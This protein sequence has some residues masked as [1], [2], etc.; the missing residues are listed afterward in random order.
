MVYDPR[1]E[2][3]EKWAVLE[4]DMGELA[5]AAPSLKSERVAM[6][7]WDVMFMKNP[8]PHEVRG[9]AAGVRWWR[10]TWRRWK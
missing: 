10:C 8:I 5:A 4:G 3:V 9:L 2:E 7:P 1:L 6:Q